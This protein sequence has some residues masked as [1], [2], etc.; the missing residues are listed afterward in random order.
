MYDWTIM[1][2]VQA[3]IFEPG[4]LFS[5]DTVW[6]LSGRRSFVAMHNFFSLLTINL[7]LLQD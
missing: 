4:R 7:L 5:L 2:G 6:M 1:D 3:R